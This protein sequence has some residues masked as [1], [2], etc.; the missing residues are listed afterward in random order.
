MCSVYAL[1]ISNHMYNLCWFFQLILLSK[2][3]ASCTQRSAAVK[4]NKP[5]GNQGN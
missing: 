5:I 2:Q 4:L 1:D 3:L